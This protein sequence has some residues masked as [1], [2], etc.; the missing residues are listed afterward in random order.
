MADIAAAR[1]RCVQ[2][3][4]LPPSMAELTVAAAAR[5]RLQL[6]RAADPSQQQWIIVLQQ[7]LQQFQSA[8]DQFFSDHSVHP[9][10]PSAA[11]LPVGPLANADSDAAIAAPANDHVSQPAVSSHQL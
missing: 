6:E 7:A 9:P 3:C 4:G 2:L 8:C 1:Q 10:T 11:L 5:E